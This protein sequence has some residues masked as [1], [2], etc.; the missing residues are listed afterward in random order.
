MDGKYIAYLTPTHKYNI[1]NKENLRHPLIQ[2]QSSL[3]I[4]VIVIL[5]NKRQSSL[6]HIIRIKVYIPGLL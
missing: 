3:N 2:A 5:I 4:L 1:V 6:V